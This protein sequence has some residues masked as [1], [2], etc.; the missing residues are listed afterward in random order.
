MAEGPAEVGEEEGEAV[1]EDKAGEEDCCGLA[2]AAGLR[3]AGQKGGPDS[4]RLDQ[5]QAAEDHHQP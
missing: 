2:G 3:Q 5:E 4:Q 1:E